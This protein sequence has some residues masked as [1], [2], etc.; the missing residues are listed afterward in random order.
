MRAWA[1]LLPD[2]IIGAEKIRPKCV[3]DLIILLSLP[4]LFRQSKTA[5]L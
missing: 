4:N 5:K 3:R 2:R 1:G